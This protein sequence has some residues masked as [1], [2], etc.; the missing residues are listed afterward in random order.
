MARKFDPTKAY[1]LEED[2]RR[3]QDPPAILAPLA[4]KK[5]QVAVDFGC[6]T[7]YFTLP[8]ARCV[9]R[10]GKVYAVDI[11]PE[12]LRLL[13]KKLDRRNLPQ[14]EPILIEERKKLPLPSRSADL[15][16]LV[17]VF[18]ELEDPARTLAEILRVLKAKGRCLIVDWKKVPKK[19]GEPGPP[20]RDRV[21]VR[22]VVAILKELG[23]EKVQAS[24]AG[25]Y[26]Y[27]ILG[28]RP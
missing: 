9:G 22:K 16:L 4:I 20:P 1:L 3:W 15:I 23:F 17:N 5:G 19:A 28:L 24:P 10:S 21:G 25:P 14:V 11:S 26:H 27:Q 6:G 7:G 8:L 2:R 12:M 13:K 18:H